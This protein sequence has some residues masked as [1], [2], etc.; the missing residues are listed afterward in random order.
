MRFGG[1][2]M[3][4]GNAQVLDDPFSRAIASANVEAT[5]LPT[6]NISATIVPG[7]AF[8]RFYREYSEPPRKWEVDVQRQLLEHAQMPT[9]WDGYSTPAPTM[10]T[11]FFALL[12]LSKVMRSR[13]PIPQVVPSSTG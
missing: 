8:P 3:L 13:T 4:G 6:G 5:L 10:D 12:V 1:G 9:G 7:A 11:A 2:Q